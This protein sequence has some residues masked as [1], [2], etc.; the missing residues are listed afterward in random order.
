[1]LARGDAFRAAGEVLLPQAASRPPRRRQVRRWAGAA[2]A[3]AEGAGALARAG[4]ADSPLSAAIDEACGILHRMSASPQIPGRCLSFHHDQVVHELAPDGS[5]VALRFAPAYGDAAEHCPSPVRWDRMRDEAAAAGGELCLRFSLFSDGVGTHQAVRL[6]AGAIGVAPAAFSVACLREPFCVSTQRCSVAGVTPR[7]LSLINDM[8]PVTNCLRVGDFA[9]AAHP[10]ALGELTGHRYDIALRDVEG[11]S[12]EQ[13]AVRIR[14]VRANGFPNFHGWQRFGVAR[15]GAPRA[16]QVGAAMLRGD[17][18]AAALALLGCR[19]ECAEAL[20]AVEHGGPAGARD[21]PEVP[22]GCARQ[23]AL[24]RGLREHG[25]PRRAVLDALPRPARAYC[26]AA[27]QAYVWNVMAS[28][29]LQ[30]YGPAARRGDL[31]FIADVSMNAAAKRDSSGVQL[32]RTDA[33]A[34]QHALRDVCIPLLG[35]LRD[36]DSG[37]PV[38]PAYPELEGVDRAAHEELLRDEFGLAL[39]DLE[40][41]V[42]AAAI[43]R[44]QFR[45]VWADCRALQ[46]LAVPAQGLEGSSPLFVTDSML[47]DRKHFTLPTVPVAVSEEWFERL[48]FDR[49]PSAGPHSSSELGAAGEAYHVLLSVVLP[50]NCYGSML[51]RELAPDAAARHA[52]VHEHLI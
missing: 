23:A 19:D 40:R 44:A 10:V 50:G 18:R 36:A 14:S 17:W 4:L 9:P 32:L 31:V 24:L 28:R 38:P 12:L 1:M 27:L 46:C 47:I 30:R 45:P 29:R 41:A 48:A 11:L 3:G 26:L 37:R 25:D 8:L 34:A 52:P 13:L 21:A 20:A 49:A 15:P 16:Q 2:A 6:M 33:D 51:L 42:G 43:F 35:V 22:A 7:Q 5:D 39:E